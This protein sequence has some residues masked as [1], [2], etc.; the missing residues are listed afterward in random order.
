MRDPFA[1]YADMWLISSTDTLRL[2]EGLK[3]MHLFDALLLGDWGLLSHGPKPGD[4]FTMYQLYPCGVVFM[5]SKNDS[6]EFDNSFAGKSYT[7]IA[8]MYDATV[9]EVVDTLGLP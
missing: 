5:G 2:V 1:H 7:D 8:I 6:I 9:S 3:D 4:D